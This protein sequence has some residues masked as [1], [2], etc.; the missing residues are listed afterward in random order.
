LPTVKCIPGHLKIS[1]GGF[2]H[3]VGASY[4]SEPVEVVVAGGLVDIVHAGVVIVTHVQRFRPDQADRAL[5]TPVARLGRPLL[6]PDARPC[7]DALGAR[8]LLQVLAWP[9]V[10]CGRDG[11]V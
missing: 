9:L 4:A 5:R 10:G 8:G 6:L 11:G 3:T 1:L 2:T 7:C